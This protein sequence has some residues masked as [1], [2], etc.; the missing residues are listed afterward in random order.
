MKQFPFC[1]ILALCLCC[2]RGLAT[3]AS[4]ADSRASAF[5]KVQTVGLNE[6]RW[7]NGFWADRFETCRAKT[8][9]ALWRIMEGT[10][11]SQFY[12]NFRIAAG[13]SEGRHRGAP[14][15]DGDFYKWLEAACAVVAVT[16]DSDWE[17][18]IDEVVGVIAKAQ[19]EDG[20]L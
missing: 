11:Y 16:H 10:N 20:Y 13:L 1:P 17:Q 19:R 3:N 9:P 8:V 5:G 4:T 12:E 6:V 7:T 2:S 14:F 18:R 15:N